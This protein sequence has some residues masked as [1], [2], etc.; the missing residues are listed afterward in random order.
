MTLALAGAAA[1]IEVGGTAPTVSGLGTVG[2]A[3]ANDHIKDVFQDA[4]DEL[5]DQLRGIYAKP[6]KFIRAWGDASVF[7]SHGATARAYG[8]YKFITVT[9]GAMAGIEVPSNPFTIMNELGDIPAKL[10]EDH[11]LALG[12]SPQILNARIGLNTSQ[13]LVKNLYLGL[14][15]GFMKLDGLTE[16]FSFTTFSIG[17]AANYQIL[18]TIDLLGGFILWRGLHLGTGL[19]YTLTD[20]GYDIK[21]ESVRQPLGAVAGFTSNEAIRIDPSL[22]LAMDIDTF[23]IP[24]E[25]NTAV[26]LLWFLNVGAGA[27]FDLGLGKSGLKVGAKGDVSLENLSSPLAQESPGK[28]TLS[29]GGDMTPAVFNLKLMA[30]VGIN[31]GPVL[32]DIPFTYYFLNNGVNAGV[33]IGVS[34]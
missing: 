4:L 16:G 18:P 14:N 8:N 33:T 27:G 30:S 22:S 15:I 5:N 31:I 2:D 26:K 13:F 28:I 10:N 32:L 3:A 11:D 19:T 7:G 17:L 9:I 1:A 12:F 29:A 6:E 24:F 23:T 34:L 21:L 20:I 25:A